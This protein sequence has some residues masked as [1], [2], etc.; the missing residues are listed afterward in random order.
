MLTRAVRNN[1]PGNLIASPWTQ[2]QCGYEGMDDKRFAVFKTFADGFCALARLMEC[3]SYRGLTIPQAIA[4]YAPIVENDTQEYIEIVLQK[5]GIDRAKKI[6]DFTA[7]EFARFLGA[8]CDV[9][10]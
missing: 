6:M 1:N 4:R 8:I 5:T 10:D 3:S 2:K 7:G 9:E